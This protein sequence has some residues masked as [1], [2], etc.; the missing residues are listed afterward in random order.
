[1]RF[2]NAAVANALVVPS[3]LHLRLITIFLAVGSLY[4]IVTSFDP[5][6]LQR[7]EHVD[8]NT[9]QTQLQSQQQQQRCKPNAIV[10]MAQ[11]QHT[12]Y[13]TRDSYSLLLNSLDLLYKNYLMIN[14]HY[15]NATVM[16]FHTGDFNS[17]DLHEM[18]SRY[19]PK[20]H[21]VMTLVNILGTSYWQLPEWLS[22]DDPSTWWHPQFSMGYRHM[23]R[24]YAIQIWNY[25][26]DQQRQL[27]TSPSCHNYRF[28]MRMDE[29]SLLHSP[30]NY[31][32]FHYMSH[33][34]Y[35]YAY[36]LCSYEMV[37]IKPIFINYTAMMRENGNH[38]LWK[39]K[40]HFNQ[41]SC[42][43]YNNWFI[44]EID[45]FLQDNVQ[46]F[47]NWI[48]RQSFIYRRRTND[49]V[50]QTATILAFANE[51]RIHRFLDWTYEHFTLD[52]TTKCPVWGALQGG[53]DDR[54][55][56]QQI[57]VFVAEYVTARNCSVNDGKYGI[58]IINISVKDMSPTYNHIPADMQNT[59]IPMVKAGKMD[60][61]HEGLNSG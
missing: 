54:T 22:G 8:N 33:H 21:G 17:T 3:R 38:P 19:D 43:F 49:L 31:D 37:A 47:L 26:R 23:I 20:Y 13:T 29:E 28:V 34:E 48:D 5:F 42:G 9:K 15:Q 61:C 4:L 52:E 36:R 14:N 11:K 27:S 1:M 24:W 57:N 25:F 18:E 51:T 60:R 30:I 35:Q 40:R 45:F 10:Y 55:A 32:L 12:S 7:V 44:G 6:S 56:H 2:S 59:M 50:I 16:I 53:Y 41:A 39:G 58:Q 46:H